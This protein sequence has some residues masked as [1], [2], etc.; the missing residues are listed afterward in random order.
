MIQKFYMDGSR[1]IPHR[2]VARAIL[3]QVMRITEGNILPRVISVLLTVILLT[4][5]L[6]IN[7][8]NRNS[9]DFS[10]TLNRPNHISGDF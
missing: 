6:L 4:V 8:P 3:Q 7:P 10:T 2:K 5:I 1:K 9:G